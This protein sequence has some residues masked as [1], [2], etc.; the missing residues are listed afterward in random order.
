M[1]S[2]WDNSANNFVEIPIPANLAV[3]KLLGI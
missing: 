3:D 1:D 2:A